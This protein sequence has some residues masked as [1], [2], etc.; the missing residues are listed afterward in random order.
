MQNNH[1]IKSAN[2]ITLK[3]KLG[4]EEKLAEFLAGGAKAVAA[5]EPLTPSWF[6]VRINAGSDLISLFRR[7]I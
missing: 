5:T 2:F 4:Q 7:L 1:S 6:S 3:A